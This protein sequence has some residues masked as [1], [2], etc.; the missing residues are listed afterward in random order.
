[1]SHRYSTGLLSGTPLESVSPDRPAEPRR[2]MSRVSDQALDLPG[3][4]RDR[5]ACAIEKE[6]AQYAL[7]A[8]GPAVATFP[9]DRELSP[10]EL[11][12]LGHRPAK[13]QRCPIWSPRI[14]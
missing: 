5:E 7:R 3:S 13:D 10:A 4:E 1:M 11:S 14:P 6:L 8:R 2:C 12:R 9:R